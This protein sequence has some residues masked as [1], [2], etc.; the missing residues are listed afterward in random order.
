MNLFVFCILNL[1]GCWLTFLVSGAN[2][3]S[4]WEIYQALDLFELEG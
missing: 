1:E 3:V 4:V 2:P